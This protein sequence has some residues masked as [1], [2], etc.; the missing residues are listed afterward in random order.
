MGIINAGTAVGA[1]IAPPLIAIVLTYSN[2]RWIFVVTGGLGLIWVWWWIKSYFSPEEHPAL[3]PGGDATQFA[4]AL[5]RCHAEDRAGA[6]CFGF[7]S[8]GGW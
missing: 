1:V 6:I 4:S 7:A 2:W 5:F 3:T 8:P